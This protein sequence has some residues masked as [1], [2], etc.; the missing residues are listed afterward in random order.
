MIERKFLHCCADYG[1]LR[2][3]AATGAAFVS[4][5]HSAKFIAQLQRQQ[6]QHTG[7]E[8]SSPPSSTS[9]ANS[10]EG[11]RPLLLD[12]I[13]LQLTE[14]DYHAAD[15]V[16]DSEKAATAESATAASSSDSATAGEHED[17][18][19]RKRSRVLPRHP[20]AEM[21]SD[22]INRIFAFMVHSIKARWER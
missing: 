11:V 7:D 20:C 1:L 16:K 14:D 10:G 2:T 22:E 8:T 17:E 15:H 18:H 3:S 12:M 9:A 21:T 5:V 4:S 19:R 13:G 6:R